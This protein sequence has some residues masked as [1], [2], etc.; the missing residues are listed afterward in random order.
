MYMTQCT[1]VL[2]RLH[3]VMFKHAE[4][5]PVFYD[6]VIVYIQTCTAHIIRNI[7]MQRRARVV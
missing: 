1:S 7:Q 6:F 5:F 2:F 3:D 4:F